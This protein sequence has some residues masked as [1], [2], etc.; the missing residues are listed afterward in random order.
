MNLVKHL[1]PKDAVQ[2]LS[3]E[4]WIRTGQPARALRELQRLSRHAWK[5][6]RTETI[7]WR[8]ARELG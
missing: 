4:R 7:L 1:Q 8:A 2:V 6:P 5:H 3:A